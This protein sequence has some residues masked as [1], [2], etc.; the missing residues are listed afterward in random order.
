MSNIV[1]GY[2]PGTSLQLNDC[3][4]CEG[5]TVETPARVDNRPGLTAIA[6]RVGTHSQFKH[7]MLARLSKI[8][9]DSPALQQLKTRAD[10]DFSIA[11][12]DAWAT[13]ADVLTF[14][15][16]RIAN[17]SYLN[18]ATEPLSLL[19]LARLI[20][21]EL[22]NGVAA[23]TYLAF[24]VEDAQGTP[25]KATIDIGTKVQSVP[26]QDELPQT[27]ETIEKIEAN[28]A[29]NAMKP[30]ITQMAWP[31]LK[32]TEVYL[33]GTTT[34]LKPG[35][36]LLFVGNE[37][38]GNVDSQQWDFRV[39]V[40]ATIESGC[41]HVIWDRPLGSQK[42]YPAQNA[43]IYTF[44][45]R[46]ALFG[47][48]APDVRT[49]P[50]DVL[51]HYDGMTWYSPNPTGPQIQ[52]AV[53]WN[54]T[55]SNPI[56]LDA[57]Y[58]NLVPT[59]NPG[60][61]SKTQ[62]SWIVL[63][64]HS[65]CKLYCVEKVSE[66]SPNKYTLTTRTTKLTL[67]KAKIEDLQYFAGQLRSVVVFAQSEE[68]EIAE[69][70]IT[71]PL[72]NSQIPLAQAVPG[73]QQGRTLIISGKQDGAK[74]SAPL[75]SEVVTVSFADNLTINLEKGLANTYD[76][77]TVT[78]Y[79]N[80]A[81]ATHGETVAEEVLGSGDASQS[82]QHFSLRQSPLTYVS[83]STP[84]GA[85]STL[86]V[87]VNDI[88]WLEVPTLYG[89]WPRSRVF[90]T[91]TADD[92]KTTVQ[93]GDGRTGA[94]LPTGQ[95]NV[96]AMYRK[97]IGQ[98]GA[99]KAGQLSLLM[100]RPLGVKEVTNL[101]DASGA[102]DSEELDDAR[103]NAPLTVRT[104]DRLVSLQDYEDFA[105]AFAGITKALATW[106]WSGQARGVF[107]TVAGTNGEAV[108]DTSSTYKKLISAMQAAGDLYVPLTIQTYRPAYFIVAARVKVD[109]GL[110][111]DK[112]LVAV[113]DAVSTHFSFEGRTFG[114][115]VTQSEVI[116]VIQA[117]PGVVAVD[118]YKLY[119]SVPINLLLP[120]F[121][122]I[123]ILRPIDIFSQLRRG[124]L[125]SISGTK[126]RLAA[127]A[128][129][130]YSGEI[131][132]R[133]GDDVLFY[134]P[135]VIRPYQ[136]EK[137]L[138]PILWAAAP[139]IGADKKMLAAEMLVLDPDIPPDYVGVMP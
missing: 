133:L 12:L 51:L 41:T 117:V 65:Y 113:K 66:S 76:R 35:D 86:K 116:A 52:R 93:F 37:R 115:P 39:V 111:T 120:D 53:E 80:V 74:D 44:R 136:P 2:T 109:S 54:F 135:S 26:G 24:T 128:I 25:G 43:R 17:E 63:S 83:A 132:P 59:N 7:S 62:Y 107:L 82:Y 40:K 32:D 68:L 112:V 102:K 13:V 9:K 131:Q 5:I 104:L 27:Y 23:S 100:N 94:R 92:G 21:Y 123:N 33:K 106:A 8:A 15:Q 81:Q 121:N 28:A 10:D 22:R 20:G 70:P 36:G 38:E 134:R 103:R 75:I 55:L 46:A 114:Q 98:K 71:D 6:Y 19:G 45:K 16:E 118:L 3:G 34:G 42:T 97:G 89:Q 58:P 47:A 124:E 126:Y 18:T 84:G 137:L 95:E 110:L 125:V 129:V 87:Y 1:D 31:K 30:Q 85:E 138:N 61:E 79:G 88:E 57:V 67:D 73:L 99:V 48:N 69:S 105:C 127:E 139:E 91:Q 90:V 64:L 29:W 72:P 60:D 101:Q 119:R 96:K 77:T 130:P 108:N 14:Y 4:C 56:N 122:L 50:D 11:L 49:L 78:I